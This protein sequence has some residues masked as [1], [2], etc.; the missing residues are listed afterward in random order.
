MTQTRT[1]DTFVL[2]EPYNKPLMLGGI[3]RC[4]CGNY[5]R[6][7]VSTLYFIPLNT[8]LV[9]TVTSLKIEFCDAFRLNLLNTQYSILKT[10]SILFFEMVDISPDLQRKEKKRQ[11]PAMVRLAS[12]NTFYFTLSATCFKSCKGEKKKKKTTTMAR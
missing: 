1:Y 9:I 6:P 3:V 7:P 12:V 8:I 5:C 10:W 4:H 11:S 2:F